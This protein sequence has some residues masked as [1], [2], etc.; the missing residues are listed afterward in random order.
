MPG[1]RSAALRILF[2]TQTYPRW[3]GDTAGP[4]IRE[5]ARGL[6][7]AG[8]RVT[9]LTPR[10][11]Q[12]RRAWDDDGVEVRSF[13]YAPRPLE[14]LGYGRSLAAD[15]HV[16]P[17]AAFAAPLYLLAAARAVARHLGR[18]RY[19]LLHAH[20]V[21]PNGLVAL[22]PGVHGKG[23]LIAAGLHGSDVFLAEKALARPAIRRALARCGLLTGCSPELVERVQRIGY[24][25][26]PSRVI[27]YGVDTDMF[28]PAGELPGEPDEQSWRERLDIPGHST[29]LLG[30][31]R[32]ATKKGFQVLVDVL[33]RLLSD[34][35]DLH[36]IIAGDG[37]QMADFQAAL[38]GWRPDHASRVHLPGAVAHDDLPGL[39][40]GADLFV[41][42][43]VHDPQGNVDGLP[44]V[45]LE[46]LASGL[47]VV[48]TTVS[49]IPL[50]VESGVQGVLVPEQD[51]A[52]LQNAIAGLLGNP[53]RRRLMG[54]RAR[55]RAVSQLT[56]D[57]VAASYRQ[58]YVDALADEAPR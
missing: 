58:A 8:D 37:D 43:A 10:A 57:I 13:A 26:K 22:W 7:R 41:L 39:Y 28:R 24:R 54:A 48:A 12:V 23:T 42:P 2:L 15:E 5:L 1:G 18:E 45:I 35:S 9:V 11:P 33:P 55:A 3:P 40:R 32:L 46:A 21:A 51:H 25:G 31:G 29:V 56:W 6:V 47:P 4:F 14:V 27:P 20:W 50:A 49:G 19:D 52:A 17:G 44:N 30:V 36:A 38:N 53:E 34:F 16:R